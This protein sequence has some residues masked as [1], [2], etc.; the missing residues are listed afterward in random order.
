MSWTPEY[1]FYS[2]TGETLPVLP[3]KYLVKGSIHFLD[4][5]DWVLSNLEEGDNYI[6]RYP[7]IIG[8]GTKEVLKTYSYSDFSE[9]D[10]L[11]ID[12]KKLKKD[13]DSKKPYLFILALYLLSVHANRQ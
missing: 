10:F 9:P 1:K 12:T 6:Y 4:T 5:R 13:I 2:P 3:G 8:I 7:G 11:G